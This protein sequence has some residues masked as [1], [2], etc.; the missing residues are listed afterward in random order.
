[1]WTG[2]MSEYA[3]SKEKLSD[4]YF[5]LSVLTAIMTR[6]ALIWDYIVSLSF[7]VKMWDNS[8][9]DIW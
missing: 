5:Y 2:M 1:M 9:P 8:E 3:T 7:K 4:S 6:N